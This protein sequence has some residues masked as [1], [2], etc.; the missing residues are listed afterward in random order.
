MPLDPQSG[1][2]GG[3]LAEHGHRCV[4]EVQVQAPLRPCRFTQGEVRE[5]LRDLFGLVARF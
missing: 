5:R 2:A 4:E 1:H 3:L